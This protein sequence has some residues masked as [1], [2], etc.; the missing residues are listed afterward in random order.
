MTGVLLVVAVLI[1]AAACPAMMWLRARRGGGPAACLAPAKPRTLD[2]LR[3]RRAE[4]D[5]AISQ[6]DSAH[7]PDAA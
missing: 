6:R 2:E 7:T 4:L 1:A 3:R 5:V